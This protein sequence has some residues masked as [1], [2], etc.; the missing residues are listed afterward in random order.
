MSVGERIAIVSCGGTIAMAP[1]G[2]SGALAPELTGAQLI[3]MVPSLGDMDVDLD[4]IE[5]FNKDSTNV[6][7]V[8]WKVLTSKL[9][10]IHPD[11]DGIVV[12]HGTDTMANTATATSFALG[13][14]L[15]IPVVFTGSQLPI[16]GR[17]TDAVVNLESAMEVTQAAAQQGISETMIV[18]S[19]RVLRAARSLKTSESRFDAFESPAFPHLA[20]LTAEDGVVFSPMARQRANIGF[21]IEARNDFDRGVLIADADATSDPEIVLAASLSDKCSALILRSV[22][23]GNVPSEGIDSFVPVI[24][25]AL[26]AGKPVIITSRFVGGKT[27]PEKYAP[28]KAAIDAGAGHAGNMTDVAAKVKLMWLLG[29]GINDPEKVSRAMLTPVVGEVDL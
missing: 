24:E 12:T 25:G 29:Q 21:T 26:G 2:D 3:D 11:Y 5:L 10:E 13:Q 20:D 15:A 16:K 8:D 27:A 9:A 4:V 28:G 17:R 1:E 14:D 7:T 19:H 22:G 18:F 6:G 23:S